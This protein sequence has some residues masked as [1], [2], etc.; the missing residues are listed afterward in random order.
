[1]VK[2]TMMAKIRDI[3]KS[4]EARWVPTSSLRPYTVAYS[5]YRPNIPSQ[6]HFY[7]FTHYE[8]EELSILAVGC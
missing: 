6:I 8:Y 2:K 4:L 5:E 3:T 1:M 7:I